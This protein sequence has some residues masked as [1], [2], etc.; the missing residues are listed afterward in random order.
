MYNL[1]Y[2][3]NNKLYNVISNT[4]QMTDAP[5]KHHQQQPALSALSP[6]N[7]NNNIDKDDPID[8]THSDNDNDIQYNFIAQSP[9]KLYNY[10]NSNNNTPIKQHIYDDE[11]HELLKKYVE[12]QGV[13]KHIEN[14]LAEHNVSMNDLITWHEICTL[15]QFLDNINFSINYK[16]KLISAMYKYHYDFKRNN[17]STKET[18]NT[19]PKLNSI[20]K[21]QSQSNSH[22]KNNDHNRTSTIKASARLTRRNS[23]TANNDSNYNNIN[24]EIN[25]DNNAAQVTSNDNTSA[26]SDVINNTLTLQS[27]NV[28][29]S[30]PYKCR[31]VCGCSKEY[32]DTPSNGILNAPRILPTIEQRKLHERYK[33]Y[34]SLCSDKYNCY[35]LI[36]D[37]LQIS[38][39]YATQADNVHDTDDT[40][41][42]I[43]DTRNVTTKQPRAPSK[44][45]NRGRT[46]FSSSK[47]K[48]RKTRVVKQPTWEV[49]AIR[50]VKMQEYLGKVQ[51]LYQ[52]KWL[53]YTED[54]NVC[55]NIFMHIH[56]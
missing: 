11:V 6:D 20:S 50:S 45:R 51:P 26:T 49:E 55:Y 42:N 18:V 9:N 46:S 39:S 31:H 8:L 15:N 35:A 25:S 19:P 43:T 12:P 53:G 52:V 3:Y 1:I 14:I 37:D 24:D 23:T 44:K 29:D 40:V 34:H 54:E 38:T 17:T 48:S 7:H 2:H 28:D 30:N 21:A 32:G 10:N 27:T 4:A 16:N 41:S 56:M 5:T 36:V 33:Q 47:S 13:S 22:N